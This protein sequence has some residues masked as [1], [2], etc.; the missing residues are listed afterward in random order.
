[1]DRITV[2]WLE[3]R[4]EYNYAPFFKVRP[5]RTNVMRFLP[6]DGISVY[7]YSNENEFNDCDNKTLVE[8]EIEL[9]DD[10]TYYFQNPNR[11]GCN[12]ENKLIVKM[13]QPVCFFVFFS[14]KFIILV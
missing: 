11:T 10:G 14:P 6:E 8:Q 9:S 7:Q 2:H 5:T 12:K 3:E 13:P 1:M 4:G